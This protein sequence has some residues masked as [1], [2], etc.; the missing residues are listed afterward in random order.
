MSWLPSKNLLEYTKCKE[1]CRGP[2]GEHVSSE[3]RAGTYKGKLGVYGDQISYSQKGLLT[4]PWGITTWCNKVLKANGLPTI[5]KGATFTVEEADKMLAAVTAHNGESIEAHCKKIGLNITAQNKIDV[6]IELAH[7]SPDR[8]RKYAESF[9]GKSDQEVADMLKRRIHGP[10]QANMKAA[11]D[12]GYTIFG[13]M[14]CGQIGK[15][16][17][18]NPKTAVYKGWEA[19]SKLGMPTGGVASSG[20]GDSS[21]GYGDSSSGA[22]GGVSK[23][24]YLGA[25][26]NILNNAQMEKLYVECKL[27]G[28]NLSLLRGEKVPVL[29]I[30][31]QHQVN[32]AE[33][34]NAYI[35]P[36]TIMD[37]WASGWFMIGGLSYIYDP[38]E[39]PAAN[40]W[41]T[42]M[43]L[44]RMEWPTPTEVTDPSARHVRSIRYNIGMG[45]FKVD[46]IAGVEDFSLVDSADAII[47][48]NDCTQR[49]QKLVKLM[50]KFDIKYRIVSARRYPINENGE[51]VKSR[52]GDTTSFA[53]V[54]FG[55]AYAFKCANGIRFFR[56][57]ISDH[58]IGDAIDIIQQDGENFNK[59][60]ADIISSDEIL[61]HMYETGLV[62]YEETAI[63]DLGAATSHFHIGTNVNFKDSERATIAKNWWE[64]VMKVRETKS[65]KGYLLTLAASKAKSLG[66]ASI[67]IEHHSKANDWVLRKLFTTDADWQSQSFNKRELSYDDWVEKAQKNLQMNLKESKAKYFATKDPSTGK[68]ILYT[69]EDDKK[70]KNGKDSDP[71]RTL[72][73]ESTGVDT[74]SAEAKKLSAQEL[75]NVDLWDRYAQDCMTAYNTLNLYYNSCMNNQMKPSETKV[76]V[77]I[78]DLKNAAANIKVILDANPSSAMINSG[79]DERLI[80]RNLLDT[81]YR[82]SVTLIQRMDALIKKGNVDI[83]RDAYAAGE[84][85]VILQTGNTDSSTRDSS[86]KDSSTRD[87]STG[88]K[89]NAKVVNIVTNSDN[90]S[91]SDLYAFLNDCINKAADLYSKC[92]NYT[93]SYYYDPIYMSVETLEE[94]INIGDDPIY[95]FGDAGLDMMPV[96]ALTGT[97]EFGGWTYLSFIDYLFDKVG[98]N[99]IVISYI[100]PVKYD[101][102]GFE[103]QEIFV[104]NPIY[105]QYGSVETGGYLTNDG[106]LSLIIKKEQSTWLKYINSV[107]EIFADTGSY[108]FD[109]GTL[110]YFIQGGGSPGNA[111]QKKLFDAVKKYVSSDIRSMW[112][113]MSD[114]ESAKATGVLDNISVGEYNKLNSP[115]KAL[116]LS[117][118]RAQQIMDV[119]E[120]NNT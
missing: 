104:Y 53:T 61:I 58:S 67:D 2:N 71:I 99:K 5:E 91:E 12:C 47:G 108:N 87:S 79:M 63:D 120:K 18:L 59:V 73:P 116:I 49:I 24:W 3:V 78:K 85:G 41:T 30:D 68:V 118:Q 25:A 57:P 100:P 77:A 117:Y 93:K 35:D 36:T 84:T 10:N 98:S 94:K 8:A 115:L 72:Y 34:D 27:R 86:T 38:I 51:I 80:K 111:T 70:K 55:G 33:Q 75:Q 52:A 106:H 62:L 64:A 107:K 110:D 50:D 42:I 74:A 66:G 109:I 7:G 97:S 81:K 105:N 39:N 23:F 101:M 112:E 14:W 54:T 13:Y 56:N 46:E 32:V 26:H 28:C 9:K 60:L 89:F 22:G 19:Y 16:D 21:G 96:E 113:Y 82:N 37:T 6:M 20:V 1:G 31:K 11:L 114:Y 29:M 103:E 45:D 65:I 40:K 95:N 69:E 43:K 48:V 92:V 76:L 119:I 44:Q 88:T 4:G 90:I 15:M 17:G 83:I 102:A